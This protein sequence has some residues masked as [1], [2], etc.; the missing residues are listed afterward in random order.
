MSKREARELKK[1]LKQEKFEASKAALIE[2]VK[3][4]HQPRTI[5][6]PVTDKAPRII[7]N[8]VQ[9]AA[10][11]DKT[12]KAIED[13]GRFGAPV[14]LCITKAD[15]EGSWSWKENRN[16]SDSEWNTDIHPHFEE[17][18]QKTWGDIDAAASGSGHKMHHDHQVS[19]LVKEARR[20]WK[21]LDLEQFDSVFRFRL[22]NKRR[23]WGYIVQAHFFMVWW[24]RNHRIYPV[25]K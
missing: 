20:R 12:P 7:P 2:K 22:G 5:I 25:D 1:A 3:D 9:A 11:F 23:A 24:E 14:T 15:R 8:I 13:G 16:W 18:M 19:D 21:K 17:F 10:P 4:D 6:E